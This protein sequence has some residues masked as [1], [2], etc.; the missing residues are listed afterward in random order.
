VSL[1][2][3]RGSSR[4]DVTAME[5]AGLG[6]TLVLGYATVALITALVIG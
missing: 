2:Y 5:R 3:A 1:F 6:Q 4:G